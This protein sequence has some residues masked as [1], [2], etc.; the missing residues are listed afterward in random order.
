MA[1]LAHAS[2]LSIGSLRICRPHREHNVARHRDLP[3]RQNDEEPH[4]IG[5][6]AAAPS[7]NLSRSDPPP[8][9]RL[10]LVSCSLSLY[11]C[12]H[13]P[14]CA[15]YELGIC[16]AGSSFHVV[17]YNATTGVVFEQ[18]TA[19]GYADWSTW[20]RGQAWGVYGFANSE[21]LLFLSFSVVWPV[22]ATRLNV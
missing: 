21:H 9:F 18:R 20:S 10:S 3:R 7:M 22:F 16:D 12:R 5:R 1:A 6:Y 13:F 19:Q 2:T 15:V 17:D 4:S 11:A 8:P 14:P